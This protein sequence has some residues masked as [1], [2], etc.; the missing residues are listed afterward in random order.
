MVALGVHA[1]KEQDISMDTN[2]SIL[3][4]KMRTR[5]FDVLVDERGIC[6]S[7]F[8]VALGEFEKYFQLAMLSE[9]SFLPTSKLI[10]E[11]WHQCII[12][13][14]DYKQMCE[15]VAPGKFLHH[16][17]ITFDSYAGDRSTEELVNEDLSWLAS[18]C[19]SFGGFTDSAVQHWPIANHF[20]KIHGWSVGELNEF[21]FD[22][23]RKF[24][25]A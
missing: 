5:L 10:D 12:E 15:R 22:L 3:S 18:Y 24:A 21:G 17:G 23:A 19:E 6:E 4:H 25:Q 1:S 16:T 9:G 2:A 20:V 14:A 13:T 8:E 11:V 7:E